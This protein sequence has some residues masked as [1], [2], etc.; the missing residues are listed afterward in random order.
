MKEKKYTF[1]GVGSK[2]IRKRV[3]E[4]KLKLTAENLL[5]AKKQGI[6][7]FRAEYHFT[8][9]EVQIERVEE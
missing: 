4:L 1:V 9:E 5:D 2:G 8:P 7:A 3:K 6:K